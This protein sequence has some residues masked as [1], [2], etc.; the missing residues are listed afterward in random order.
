MNIEKHLSRWT[1]AGIISSDQ[2]K[3]IIQFEAQQPSA[4]WI[5]FGLSG[6]GIFVV[7]TGV[8]SLVAANWYDL[9]AVM[10]LCA[11]FTVFV[12]LAYFAFKR[13]KIEGVVREALLSAFGLYALAGIGLIGQI[14][15]LRSDGYQGL[16]FWL[17]IILPVSLCT[18][19]KLLN[20]IWFIGFA[21][22]VSMWVSVKT[23][24]FSKEQVDLTPVYMAISL[25]YL[26]LVI[27]YSLPKVLSENYCSAARF[28]SYVTILIPFAIFGNFAWATNG[29]RLYDEHIGVLPLIPITAALAAL[30]AVGLRRIQCGTFLTY[31]ICGTIIASVLLFLIPFSFVTGA[32][33]I[34]GCALFITTWSG[35]AAIAVAIQRKALFD[36]AA[37]VIGLRFIIVYFEVFG[38]L[39]ATGLGLIVSGAVIL[40]TAYAWHRYRGQVVKTI[41]ESL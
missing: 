23:L 24:T 32:H 17:A 11:Y 10:K 15:H 38:S 16:F 35:A 39:A 19:S 31:A 18:K 30:A 12:L 4:G 20:N 21:I 13:E 7:L 40:G 14:Y 29:L 41:Q 9:S 25:P 22:A 34:L 8:V 2:S 3:A 27:G 26:F 33:D 6:L 5:I 1:D 37:L 28:W 36:F